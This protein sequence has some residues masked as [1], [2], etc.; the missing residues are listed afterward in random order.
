MVTCWLL[1]D[2]IAM[3][4]SPAARGAVASVGR[5]GWAGWAGFNAALAAGAISAAVIASVTIVAARRGRTAA[6]EC[7]MNRFVIGGC[8]PFNDAPSIKTCGTEPGWSEPKSGI[9]LAIVIVAPDC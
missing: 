9:G 2:T 4:G 6:L 7:A 3:I 1:I 5:A 8:F